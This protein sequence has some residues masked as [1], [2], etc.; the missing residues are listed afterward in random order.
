[1][2][3]SPG[4]Y[5]T[6]LFVASFFSSFL[7]YLEWNTAGFAL[8]GGSLLILPFLAITDRI[9]FD[10]RRLRRTGL[11][12]KLIL[13]AFGS[14]DRL[15]LKDIEQVETQ[16]QRAIKRAGSIQ[17]RYRTSFRGKGVNFSFAS[18]GE[19][20]RKMIRAILPK[21]PSEVLDNRSLEI[22]DYL[23]ERRSVLRRAR[24]SNIPS[25]DVLE[26]A[27]RDLRSKKNERNA[28]VSEIVGPVESDKAD[29]L[30]TL[31]NELRISGAFLQAVEAFRRALV[32]KPKDPWLLYE[33]AR[34]LH[35]FAGSER[36]DRLERRA[37]AMLRLAE[38][39]AG[40]D[41]DLLA[42]LGESY[43]QI[44]DWR[45]AAQVFKR[46][47][48]RFGSNFRSVRGLAEIALREGK[49]AHVIHN[50]A[51]ANRLTE[52]SA[53]KRWTKGEIDY[54]SRLNE[55]D[56]YMELEVSRV[57]LLDSLE[58]SKRT[59]L[60]VSIAGLPVI[61]YGLL[62]ADDLVANIGW[63]ISVIGVSVWLGMSVGRKMLE[64]RIPFELLDEKE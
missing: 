23:D 36:D 26:N 7:L 40:D 3:V 43:F 50:F 57:N 9:Y 15:R 16:A 61:L 5:F 13:R 37:E 28:G 45:R 42:R 51:A 55:D 21:L 19:A 29:G 33:F 39:R 63:A 49:I 56:E 46:A 17:Y 22:R 27:L 47:V 1:I 20:Y 14:R 54:F 32:I 10:G 52:S 41:P 4:G 60:R 11:L 8:L 18:G 2:R 34:C 38:R 53:L 64:S 30:R 35:S 24:S 62:F 6:A 25:G 31:A 44:G 48:D 58:R 59:S 12:P